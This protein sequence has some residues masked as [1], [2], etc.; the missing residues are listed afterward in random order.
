M[1]GGYENERR[2]R[3]WKMV[4]KMNQGYKELLRKW[5]KVKKMKKD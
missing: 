5:K 1:W 2:I 3:K 4:K